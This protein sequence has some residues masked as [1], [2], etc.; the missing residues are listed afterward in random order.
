MR[1]GGGDAGLLWL[2]VTVSIRACVR[3]AGL[4]K[5]AKYEAN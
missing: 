4:G 1:R 3:D 2:A 5:C